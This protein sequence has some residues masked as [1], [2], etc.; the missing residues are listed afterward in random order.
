MAY[1]VASPTAAA[2]MIEASINAMANS[3]PTVRPK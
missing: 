2:P 3:T 1:E